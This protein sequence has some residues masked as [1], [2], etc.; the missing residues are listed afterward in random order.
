MEL[1]QI[2]KISKALS[3]VN[4]LKILQYMQA[5]QGCIECMEI[6]NILDLAQPSISHHIRK[7]VEAGLIEPHKAGRF[8]NYSLNTKTWEAYLSSLTALP[9][10]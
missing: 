2:E 4:R 6:P 3:D 7:L 8:Y 9:P 5:N 1:R 10:G